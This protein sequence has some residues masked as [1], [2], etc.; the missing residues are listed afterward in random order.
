MKRVLILLSFV[1]LLLQSRSYASAYSINS[2][3]EHATPSDCWVVFENSVYDLTTYLP[4]HK[5]FL[6]IQSW[7]GK[8]MTEDFKNKDGRNRD[9][10]R[11]SYVL[12]EKYKIGEVEKQTD[13]TSKPKADV[14]E[15]YNL[16]LPLGIVLLTYWGSY[17]FVKKGILKKFTI[18][19]FNAFWNTVLFLTLLIPSFGFG[20]FMMVRTKNPNLYSIDFDFMYWHVELSVVMG[21]VA[22][23]HFIQRIEIYFKQVASNN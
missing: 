11:S 10:I 22:I 5:R 3:S 7:C 1:V 18:V 19:K 4:L 13:L 15:R 23:S 21:A 14:S 8:D 16:I 12:L 17:F 6:D 20:V 9:H 2:I